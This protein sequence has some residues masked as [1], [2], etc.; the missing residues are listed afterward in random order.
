MT[1]EVVQTLI[2]Q[3]KGMIKMSKIREFVVLDDNSIRCELKKR[4][5]YVEIKYNAGADL[6]AVR[7]YQIN[8]DSFGNIERILDCDYTDVYWED[9]PDY[10]N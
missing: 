7:K 5:T 4:G 1:S 2:E 8:I 9:L 6:Y 10:F 3:L